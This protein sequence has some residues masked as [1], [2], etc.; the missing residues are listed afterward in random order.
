MISPSKLVTEREVNH[1]VLPP[2][3]KSLKNLTLN[4]SE[5]E[6]AERFNSGRDYVE[7]T[8]T[9]CLQKSQIFCFIGYFYLFCFKILI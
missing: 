5:N 6:E 3:G 4:M 8:T 2:V 1:F 9:N 7:E